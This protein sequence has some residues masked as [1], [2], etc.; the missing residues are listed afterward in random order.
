MDYNEYAANMDVGQAYLEV[1]GR[2]AEDGFGFVNAELDAWKASSAAAQKRS[3]AAAAAAVPSDGGS[4]SGAT[5]SKSS[6]GKK[7][8]AVETEAKGRSKA[9]KLVKGKE[10]APEQPLQV[11]M[12]LKVSLG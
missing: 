9:G 10:T 1:M 5:N 4:G 11:T 2:A 6:A 3:I 12:A 8:K 7:G